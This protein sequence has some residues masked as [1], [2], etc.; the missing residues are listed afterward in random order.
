MKIFIFVK[1]ISKILIM[2]N[3]VISFCSFL[4]IFLY[5]SFS[6]ASAR[7]EKRE[8]RGAWIATVANIDWPSNVNASSEEKRAELIQ[9]LDSLRKCKINA[10]IFQIRPTAD[11][12]YKSDIEP[13]SEW[14]TGEQGRAP[15]PFFDPLQLV[16]EEAHKRCMEVHAWINPYRVTNFPNYKLA[17]NH[18][19]FKKPHLFKTYGERIYFD[20]GLDETG[21]YLIRVLQDIVSRYDIDALHLDDYFYPYPSG[22]ADF[23]DEETF[24]NN[25]RGFTS[26]ADWRRDNVN[27]IVKRIQDSVK[28]IKPWVEF[29]VSPFG[30]WRNANKDP[31]GSA[32]KAGVTNYDDLY[33]DVIL[34]ADSGW[35]DYLAPQL[36]WELGKKVADYAVLAPW[37]QDNVKN[38]KLYFGLYASGL[39]VNKPKAWKTPNEL[40]RQ[41]RF[42]DECINNDGVIFYSTKYFLKNIQGLQDSLQTDFYRHHAL[43]PQS[44]W[45]KKSE[46]H[47]PVNLQLDTMDCLSWDAVLADDG[48]AISYYVVYAFPDS[49]ECDFDDPNYILEITP[50]T[51]IQLS[52]YPHLNNSI[53]CITVTAV[54]R[55][56]KESDP[57]EFIVRTKRLMADK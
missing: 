28:Q 53:Y 35:V 9:I 3:F 43:P 57:Y 40:V 45:G 2:K 23:P 56:R 31:K 11:A 29:G 30:V 46:A 14:I 13:W 20:P 6:I 21:D 51:K 54:N 5:G 18:I 44:L 15:E 48:E 12:L 47:F 41:L 34:W 37:W 1:I 17:E 36:Y 55:F 24:Q 38:S 10:V 22:G 8:F 27:R 33:A 50:N 49:L 39:E 25:P 42:N 32:T 26:K 16:V 52:D 19:Y 4:L 7:P